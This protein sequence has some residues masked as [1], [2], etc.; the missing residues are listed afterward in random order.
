MQAFKIVVLVTFVTFTSQELVWEEITP[1]NPFK[2]RERRD[3]AI[4]YHAAEDTIYIFGGM[5]ENKQPLKDMY[6]FNLG[7]QTWENINN[8]NVEARFG[9][10]FGSRGD[11]MYVATGQGLDSTSKQKFYDD[12][13]RFQFSNK[14]WEELSSKLKPKHRYSA[15]GGIHESDSTFFISHGFGDDEPFSDSFSYDT[16]KPA[17]TRGWEELFSGTN[18]YDPRYPHARFQHS[19]IMVSESKLVLFGGCLR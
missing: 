19:S 5:A 11:F 2:P 14:S 13:W 16:D 7:T 10:V 1:K 3:S 15:A 12:I 17:T 4:G 9:T 8:L 18:N 6:K